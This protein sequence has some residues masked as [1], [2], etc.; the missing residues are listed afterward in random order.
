MSLFRKLVFESLEGRLRTFL[1]QLSEFPGQP[2]IDKQI[3]RINKYLGFDIKTRVTIMGRSLLSQ[4]AP[5]GL[6]QQILFMPEL[7]IKLVYKTLKGILVTWYKTTDFT[8]FI[9]LH[10]IKNRDVALQIFSNLHY[11]Y[12]L[13]I[14]LS[15]I[16]W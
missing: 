5:G 11:K 6:T 4:I 14:K 1:A 15:N 8:I 2:S 3:D 10:F 13:I 12:F 9:K 7:D 16:L